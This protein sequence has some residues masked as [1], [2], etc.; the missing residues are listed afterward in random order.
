MGINKNVFSKGKGIKKISKR[1]IYNLAR[2]TIGVFMKNT[3]LMTG[4]MTLALLSMMF[5]SCKAVI[6]NGEMTVLYIIA[7]VVI[8]VV[9]FALDLFLDWKIKD[10]YF[11]NPK[12]AGVIKIFYYGLSEFAIVILMFLFRPFAY[13]NV[14]ALIILLAILA[15][16]KMT[17]V[18]NI[19]KV[20]ADK[21][22]NN[23]S[24]DE[25]KEY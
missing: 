6:G 9:F 18:K 3:K 15:V 24:G 21:K 17:T 23:T 2:D 25:S 1:W 11:P 4:L 10:A 22:A 12:E 13:F 5:T 19:K 16:D 14:L 8:T 7:N 20:I